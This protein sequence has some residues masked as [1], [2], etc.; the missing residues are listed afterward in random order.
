LT[1][2]APA[3][4][5]LFV[6]K[7][8]T[9]LLVTISREAARVLRRSTLLVRQYEAIARTIQDGRV[10]K[11]R[12]ACRLTSQEAR[13][14]RSWCI[15][16]A[17]RVRALEVDTAAVLEGAATDV[18]AAMVQPSVARSFEKTRSRASG[19]DSL[20]PR[21]LGERPVSTSP[22]PVRAGGLQKRPGI[23]ARDEGKGKRIC[24]LCTKSIPQD[25]PHYRRGL[26]WLHTKCYEKTRPPT[27][28]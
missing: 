26:A 27:R 2:V 8:D 10:V 19:P 22:S 12:W 28:P 9:P 11:G 13:D 6:P 1:S 15:H 14:L 20:T 7:R 18:S 16:Q 21:Q 25:E 3:R 24:A 4:D 23:L 17:D 5:N